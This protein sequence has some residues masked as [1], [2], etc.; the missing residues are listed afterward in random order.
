M[1]RKQAR[2]S[3]TPRD[4]WQ[5]LIRLLR[6]RPRSVTEARNRLRSLKYSD[7]QIDDTVEKAQSAGLL[8]DEAFAKLWIEDRMLNHP[9][10]RRAVLQELTDKGIDKQISTEML[11]KVYPASEEKGIALELAQKRL[12]RYT[13]LDRNSRVQKT[14]S[15][16]ARRG[17]S[18]SL[19]RSVVDVAETQEGIEDIGDHENE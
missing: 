6:Y 16:L 5:A 7:T 4:P 15:F 1:K 19:A 10:S 11:D 17:F 9:L 2:R 12:L 14:I 3:K 13:S 18:F 8:D